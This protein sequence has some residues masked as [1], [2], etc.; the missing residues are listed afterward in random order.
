MGAAP[1][2]VNTW[3][4]VPLGILE[5]D[6][7]VSLYFT[8]QKTSSRGCLFSLQSIALYKLRP[9]AETMPVFAAR[10]YTSY[11]S[12]ATAPCPRCGKMT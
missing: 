2:G 5:T 8:R 12:Q 4:K 11:E 9:Q 7:D 1:T 3:G 10:I 6:G